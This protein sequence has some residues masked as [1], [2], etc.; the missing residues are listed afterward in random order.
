MDEIVS[1]PAPVKPI[2]SLAE[3]LA[4]FQAEAPT[5]TKGKTAKVKMKTGGEYS[6]KYADLSDILP[7]VSPLLAKY[8][9][10]WSSKPAR[11]E[12]GQ[13]VLRYRLLHTSGETDGDEMPLGVDPH[14]KPQ[15]LGSAITYMRR[16]AMTAQLNIATEEDD[17]GKAAQSADRTSRPA[18]KSNGSPPKLVTAKDIEAVKEAMDGLTPERIRLAFNSVGISGGKLGEIPAAKA[19][20]LIQAL[21]AA[22]G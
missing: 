22:Q 11:A 4:A 18:A 6:Y 7:V 16:Y 10:S 8:G 5:F 21:G 9:L 14:C 12:D 3:A 15:E 20:P 13:L 1:E 2:A 19:V 17:D